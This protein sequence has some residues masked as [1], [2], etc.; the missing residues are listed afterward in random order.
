[1]G[2]MGVNMNNRIKKMCNHTIPVLPQAYGDELSYYE[3]LDKALLKINEITE[4]TNIN[5][6]LLDELYSLF[7]N[8][9]KASAT[10]ETFINVC[11]YGVP[12]DGSDATDAINTLLNI[13]E[14]I[15]RTFYFPA[16]TYNISGTITIDTDRGNSLY[17][18]GGAEIVATTAI[19]GALVK[20]IGKDQNERRSFVMNGE[21][22]CN[23]LANIGWD[24][25][26]GVRNIVFFN[27]VITRFIETGVKVSA[28]GSNHYVFENLKIYAYTNTLVTTGMDINSQDDFFTNIS[29]QSI[30]GIKLNNRSGHKFSNVHLWSAND[31]DSGHFALSVGVDGAGASQW[32]NLYLDTFKNGF[33]NSTGLYCSN[34]YVYWYN[35]DKIRN[36]KAVG[37]I[38]P[39]NDCHIT[40][41]FFNNLNMPNAR[42]IASPTGSVD[43]YNFISESRFNVA[44]KK[45][46]SVN[47]PDLGYS[48]L[49]GSTGFYSA[50][51]D[52]QLIGYVLNTNGTI[53]LRFEFSD[54]VENVEI[55]VVDSVIH[56]ISSDSP[57]IEFYMPNSSLSNG[58]INGLP[59]VND[60]SFD[61]LPIYVKSLNAKR[62][63]LAV[64]GGLFCFNNKQLRPSSSFIPAIERIKTTT[65]FQNNFTGS[66]IRYHMYDHYEYTG[67]LN[68]TNGT[69]TNLMKESHEH[70]GYV[71]LGF[72]NN[73]PTFLHLSLSY[74]Q[75]LPAL[76][77]PDKLVFTRVK[78]ST[79]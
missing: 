39:A 35:S 23:R 55:A 44:G 46:R 3:T 22:N 25:A 20:F 30:I 26:D 11:K 16:G 13:P 60:G 56:L 65:E 1:M 57:E 14:L 19:D 75:V 59:I 36:E 58:T 15:G 37:V 61:Y 21:F 5:T 79:L 72:A 43:A 54:N 76:A 9:V 10:T 51:S 67:E 66:L 24:I 7:I 4:Q 78:T 71:M 29:I 52:V 64:H 77:S 70:D 6:K 34:L 62:F 40:N 27:N 32:S 47:E 68:R 53:K 48:N 69:T 8:F 50:F 38:A 31:I 12:S 63:R 17:F 2:Y 73:V 33:I 49:S 41:Y 18:D 45:Y 42:A 74:L 28:S